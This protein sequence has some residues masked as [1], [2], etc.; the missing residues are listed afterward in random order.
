[1]G[2]LIPIEPDHLCSIIA[3]NAGV[4]KAW[5]AFLGGL[6]W[7]V[8]HS[9]GMLT[10]CVIFLPLQSLI[11]VGL[12]EHYGNYIA[13]L[14]LIGIG[15]YFMANESKYLEVAED[16]SWVPKQEACSC[17]QTLDFHVH[18]HA[19][20]GHAHAAG[21][22]CSSQTADHEHC[23]Q[24]DCCASGLDPEA[25][26]TPLLAPEEKAGKP[27]EKSLLPFSVGELRGGLVGMLQGLC[28]PSCIAGLAFIGQMGAQHPSGLEIMSFFVI[29]FAS[30]V[31]FSAIISVAVVAFGRSCSH[32]FST[33]TRTIFR[34]SCIFSIALGTAWIA[35][36]ACGRLH[37]IEYTHPIEERLHGMAGHNGTMMMQDVGLIE[38]Y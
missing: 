12:W 11:R 38:R 26:S 7:G 15:C 9:I 29:C 23:E 1:M 24:G 19:H 5:P 6:A 32:L 14:L 27:I 16:G 30:V 37:V 36:N 28:C 22:G 3:L 17:C 34:A 35:L 25:E 20:P 21:Q 4:R 33:S 8:G 13:G 18:S 31:F 10:F 2:A